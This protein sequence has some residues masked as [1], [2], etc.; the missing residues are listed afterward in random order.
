MTIL[1][2]ANILQHFASSDRD[3]FSNFMHTQ[4]FSMHAHYLFQD[5]E[6]KLTSSTI[7]LQKLKDLIMMEEKSREVLK[8]YSRTGV[9]DKVSVA[10][11]FNNMLIVDGIEQ[12]VKIAPRNRKF[13]GNT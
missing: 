7:C 4:M 3:F 11:R 9:Q 13:L 2:N 8:H 12:C 6:S 10:I 1:D 5:M